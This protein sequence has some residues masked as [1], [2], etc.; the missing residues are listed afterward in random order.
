MVYR[1]LFAVIMV[2]MFMSPIFAAQSTIIESEG[3]ACLG[4]DRSRKQTEQAALAEAKKKAVENVSTYVKSETTV[5]DFALQKDLLSA[6][7]QAEVKVVQEIAADWYKSS[8]SGDCYK[9]KIKAEV[10][11]NHAAM[12]KMAA[13]APA[14]LEDPSAPLTVKLWADKT[15]YKTGE[16]I[17]IYLKGNKPFYARVLYRDAAGEVIQLLP[18]PFRTA[19]YF[20]GGTVYEIP[21]GGDQ[22]D[23]AVAPPFGEENIVVYASTTPLGDIRME[24]RGG[25][26][27]VKTRKKDISEMTRGVKIIEKKDNNAY[28]ASAVEFF[29]DKVVV[30]TEK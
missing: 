2:V 9:V 25:V 4:D 1:I 14:A 13:D 6:L 27:K 23:L 28:S 22:F 12:E 18:N 19:D 17:R 24:T 5:K 11:P 15:A 29:E 30:K 26:Y 3:N 16:K 20:N 7:A 21:A 8:V 10:I